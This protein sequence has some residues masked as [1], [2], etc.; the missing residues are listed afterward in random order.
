MNEYL[1]D[2]IV[3]FAIIMFF[4]L[5]FGSAHAIHSWNSLRRQFLSVHPPR[6]PSP[7]VRQTPPGWSW[8]EST[9]MSTYIR[10][11]P[12]VFQGFGRPLSNSP[13]RLPDDV[14]AG[15]QVPAWSIAI[16]HLNGPPF[17]TYTGPRTNS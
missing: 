11:P 3:I 14:E 2:F 8:V 4:V 9:T 12:T 13:H 17:G 6:A 10:P 16:G 1:Q 15:V 5:L 7:H